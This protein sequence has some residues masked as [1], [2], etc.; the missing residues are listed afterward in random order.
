MN[1]TISAGT[2]VHGRANVPGSYYALSARLSAVRAVVYSFHETLPVD[3]SGMTEQAGAEI[4]RAVG[5]ASAVEDL[6][7]LCERDLEEIELQLMA[8]ASGRAA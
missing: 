7:D 6:L 5:L 2:K 1:T 4:N 3:L 8:G